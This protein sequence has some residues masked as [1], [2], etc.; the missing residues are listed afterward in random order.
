[1]DHRSAAV[2]GAMGLVLGACAP[3]E[4]GTTFAT[5]NRI[6]DFSTDAASAIQH[7]LQGYAQ[8]GP[9]VDGA[10]LIVRS[11]DAD[12]QPLGPTATT[13]TEGPLGRYDLEVDFEGNAIVEVTGEWYDE[14]TGELQPPV[15]LSALVT[16][17]VT[18][19]VN[20]NV[21][22]HLSLQA[23]EGLVRAGADAG[24]AARGAESL[25][26]EALGLSP[27]WYDPE[28]HLGS[29]A[30]Q[31]DDLSSAYALL[32][33]AT[34]LE[35]AEAASLPVQ[36]W[37]DIL[38]EDLGDGALDDWNADAIAAAADRIDLQ[39]LAYVSEDW[40]AG[41][42][43]AAPDL[44]RLTDFD[45]DGIPDHE[46]TDGDNDGY[47]GVAFGG[48]DC[49]DRDGRTFPYGQKTSEPFAT[50]IACGTDADGDGYQDANPGPGIDPGTDCD[51]SNPDVNPGTGSCSGD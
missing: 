3:E 45:D 51:D 20:V 35:A 44:E 19:D 4:T 34:L 5:E 12:L 43:Q 47:I 42:G 16:L 10:T 22:S 18:G 1:M 38:S 7:D 25:V 2:I 33:S 27:S 36:D 24:P 49:D 50:T 46:D 11:L 30:I 15:T 26:H 31:G 48:N 41:T 37:L 28:Q 6:L 17:P 13:F 32:T 8:K 39:A 21:F 40:F 29:L 9:F 14:R 23:T